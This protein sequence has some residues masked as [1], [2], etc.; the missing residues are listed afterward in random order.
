MSPACRLSNPTHQ[1]GLKR[2]SPRFPLDFRPHSSICI[3]HRL[4]GGRTMFKGYKP[5]LAQGGCNWEIS[6]SATCADLRASSRSSEQT[7]TQASELS[8]LIDAYLARPEWMRLADRTRYVW[9]RI[10]ERIRSRWE[11]TP[12][13]LLPEHSQLQAILVWRNEFAH[14]PRT[15]DHQL[16]VPPHILAWGLHGA[17]YTVG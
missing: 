7:T 4:D 8:T 11:R 3:T 10:V 17:V 12:I 1:L 9:R 14:Q 5:Q 13:K 6:I 15:A 2:H 16:S